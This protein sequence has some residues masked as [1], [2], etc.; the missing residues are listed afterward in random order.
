MPRRFVQPDPAPQP[1]LERRWQAWCDLREQVARAGLPVP[2]IFKYTTP[3][4]EALEPLECLPPRELEHRYLENA[5]LLQEADWFL[6]ELNLSLGEVPH[7]VALLD[8]EGWCLRVFGGADS[9]AE[10]HVAHLAPGTR[11][12][13]DSPLGVLLEVGLCDGDP[14]VALFPAARPLGGPPG[15]TMLLLP[16]RLPPQGN[17]GVLLL[18]FSDRRVSC[19]AY[20]QAYTASTAIEHQLIWTD[21]LA[22]ADRLSLVGTMISQIV[23][24]VKNPLAAMKAALQLALTGGPAERDECLRLVDKEI[25]E[26]NT[27]VENL[28]GLAKPA[29][30]QFSL[31][32]LETILEDVLG[33]I[34]YEVSLRS[35]RIDFQAGKTAS[36]LRCDARLL[37]QAFLNLAR[38]AIQAM[39]QGGVLTFAIHRQPQ[40][41]GVA[42]E[43]ADTGVGIS[44]ENVAHLFEPFFTTKGTAGTGLGLSVTRRIIQEAHQGEI[45]VQSTLGAGTRFVVFLPFNPEVQPAP[46]APPPPRPGPAG[47]YSG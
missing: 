28:L 11:A 35:I 5:V 46:T 29:P 32:C 25:E 2:R 3:L 14:C 24:E 10:R 19:R 38:N 22:Q 20:S 16:L 12:T 34:R 9:L 4:E 42:I 15:W 7:R 18:S 26:L 27:L 39:P 30:A 6:R 33:L 8:R 13:A 40:R 1:A 45:A 36:F 17:A 31:Q 21:R 43:V 41:G 37:K 23:H 44:P 47:G